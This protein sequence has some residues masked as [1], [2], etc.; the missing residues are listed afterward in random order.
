[1]AEFDFDPASAPDVGFDLLPD[2]DYTIELDRAERPDG[3]NYL[4]LVFVVVGGPFD[5]RKLFEVCNLWYE[6]TDEEKQKKTVAIAQGT[7]KQIAFAIGK[8]SVKSSDEMLGI[9]MLARVRTQKGKDGYEDKNKI[10]KYMTRDGAS[11][12]R[13]A[14]AAAS[15]QKAT[16]P[17]W[18]R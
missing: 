5:G 3:K 9:P 6:N 1:M 17:A 8:P 14:P 2:A 18:R 11:P 10:V 4:S 15:A 7:I 12:A 16:G 13:G